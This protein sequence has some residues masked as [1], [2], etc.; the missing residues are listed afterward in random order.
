M[1]LA[2]GIDLANENDPLVR[3]LKIAAKDNSPSGTCNCEH[4]LVS[5]G[6]TDPLR[7]GYSNCSTLA[8]PDQ[9]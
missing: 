9:R 8:W 2:L 3:G 5:Q 6:A 1:H 7:A 4:I